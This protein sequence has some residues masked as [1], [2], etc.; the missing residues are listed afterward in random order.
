MGV[1]STSEFTCTLQE[2][3]SESIQLVGGKGANLGELTGAGLPVP[4]AFCVN[5]LAYSRLLETN[6]LLAPILRALEGLDYDDTAE[7]ERRAQRIR[8]MITTADVPAD[9]N[10]AIRSA[11]GRL[12]SE[13]GQDVLVSVRSSATAEDLPGMSFAGQQDTYLNIYGADSV[14]DHVRQ[15]WASLWTDR[16]ISYRH[17]QGFNQSGVLLAVVV[18][19]M[20]PSDVSGVLFTANPVTSNP[21]ELFLNVSWGL[22]EAIVSG[23]V[24][25]DRYLIDK[26]SLAITDREIHEKLVMTVRSPGGQGSEH[27]DVPVDRRSIET[28]TDDQLRELSEIGLRIEDHYGFPQDIEWGYSNGRFA[29]LQSR[30]VTGA[31][32]EFNEDLEFWQSPKAFSELYSDK[33]TWSRSYSDEL[34]TGPSTPMMYTGGQPHRL[35]TKYLAL[36]FMGVTEFAGYKAEDFWDMPQFR[37]YGARAYYNTFFEKEWIRRFIPP[38]ARDEVA[39]A[40]F[41][42]EE[43]EEIKNTPFDWMEFFSILVKLELTHPE[44]SLLGSTHRLYEYLENSANHAQSVMADFDIESAS[45][46]EIREAQTR[47]RAGNKWSEAPPAPGRRTPALGKSEMEASVGTPFNWYLYWLPHGLQTMCEMWLGDG[48]LFS[49]LVS[50]METPTSEQNNAVWELSRTIK[51]SPDLMRL[52]GKEDSKE[53]LDALQETEDGQQFKSDLDEF[54]KKWGH[55]GATERDTIY[56]RW[57]EKPENVFPSVKAM[58]PLDDE[59]GPPAFEQRLKERMLKTKEECLRKIRKQP[60]GALKAAFFKWYLELV[61]DYFYYRDWERFTNGRAGGGRGRLM[62]TTIAKQYVERGLMKDTED[63]FFLGSN[64]MQALEAGDM[65]ARDVEL[66]VRARRRVYGRYTHNEPAKYIRGWEKFDDGQPDDGEGLRGTA[67]SAGVITGR[68]RVCRTLNE[69]NKVEKGD[70]LITVATDPAWTTVYSFT[71]GVVVET[72]GVVS[73]AVMISRE[74]GIPCV[75]NLSRACDLIPDGGL[76][77]VDGNTGR[78]I[79]HEEE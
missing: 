63:I 49:H 66:R 60:T 44:R 30:E 56:F 64:E 61:Q 42:E 45:P 69:I 59:D 37:R 38:F 50:G 6:S 8:E 13:L 34:Q 67:A 68:A 73:H 65:S 2:I 20:F 39:L 75:A 23:K 3:D 35:R 29:V 40:P 15:C 21:N 9:V 11:Y 4:H 22:G 41:P 7:I 71:G 10:S 1:V 52:M 51:R 31:D 55:L 77:T 17:R 48:N 62:L 58:L 28:L 12:E 54:I 46:E 72:G 16:A 24:N 26:K 36:E 57:A 18:Q 25:P 14:V 27:V 43:R 32:I 76:I 33:W 70:I 53:I 47:A 74:Y 79:I 5:T 19:E 78:V